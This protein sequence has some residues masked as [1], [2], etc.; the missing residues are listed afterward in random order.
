M[1]PSGGAGSAVAVGSDDD[2]GFHHGCAREDRDFLEAGADQG[3]V[4]VAAAIAESQGALSDIHPLWV[5]AVVTPLPSVILGIKDGNIHDGV[6][7]AFLATGVADPEHRLQAA[8]GIDAVGDPAACTGSRGQEEGHGIVATPVGIADHRLY[9]GTDV[10]AFDV[11]RRVLCAPLWR[12]PG[13]CTGLGAYREVL[14]TGESGGI[15]GVLGADR[16]GYLAVV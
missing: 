11:G 16:E 7:A 8:P 12:C 10:R 6:E 15:A 4:V 9:L 14:C 1:D 3:F 2:L 5:T 13:G